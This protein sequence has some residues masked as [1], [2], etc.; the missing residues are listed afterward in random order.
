VVVETFNEHRK[1]LLCDLHISSVLV[2]LT[3]YSSFFFF[4]DISSMALV[5]TTSYL[6]GFMSPYGSFANLRQPL[7]YD[8]PIHST[9]PSTTASNLH[10]DFPRNNSFPSHANRASN[11]GV[12]IGGQPIRDFSEILDLHAS[13]YRE[14][15]EE[16]RP[17]GKG[18]FGQVTCVRNRLDGVHYAIKKIRLKTEKKFNL[19]KVRKVTGEK[20]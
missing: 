13:R 15:F 2:E 8:S 19:E 10:G 4:R 11:T 18:A 7:P 14:D 12:G 17:L 16:V 20:V 3:L 9:R 6:S 5:R 1:F